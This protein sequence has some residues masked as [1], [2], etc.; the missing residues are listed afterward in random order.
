MA[1]WLEQDGQYALIMDADEAYFVRSVFGNVGG[2]GCPEP[3]YKMCS[4]VYYAT[5]HVEPVT[6]DNALKVT[7]LDD[8]RVVK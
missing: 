1:T 5:H 4:D 2:G 6:Y 8:V 7:V 3:I